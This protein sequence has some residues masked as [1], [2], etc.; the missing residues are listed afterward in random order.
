[1][2][3][4]I[5]YRMFRQDLFGRGVAALSGAEQSVRLRQTKIILTRP[6]AEA[7]KAG[8]GDALR[9]VVFALARDDCAAQRI[10]ALERDPA[11]A[12]LPAGALLEAIAV[13][14]SAGCAHPIQPADAVEAASEPCR[15]LNRQLIA[16]DGRRQVNFLASPLIGGGIAVSREERMAIAAGRPDRIQDARRLILAR[17]RIT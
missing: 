6:P 9:A 10:D 14:V 15:R 1:M 8:D 5:V 16:L 3:D 2:R 11:I 12:A 13:L 7:F 4:F 17:L